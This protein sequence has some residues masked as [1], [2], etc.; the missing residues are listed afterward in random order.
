M[1]ASAFHNAQAYEA[2]APAATAI[3]ITEAIRAPGGVPCTWARLSVETQAIRYRIDGGLPTAAVGHPVATGVTFDIYG[4][5]NVR[6]LRVIAQ[7]G[8]ASV[9]VTTGTA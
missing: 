1:D 3:G 6:N 4:E 9:K 8:T 7:T 5:A 2:L